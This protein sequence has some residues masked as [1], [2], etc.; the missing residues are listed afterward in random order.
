MFVPPHQLVRLTRK[1][2]IAILTLARPAMHNALVPEL[3][4]DVLG[5]LS[6][7]RADT[8]IAALV[9]A[10]DGP[11]FSIGGD[12]RRFAAEGQAGKAQL[13]AY[14]DRLV[15]LLNET[16]LAMARL[17]QP[18]VAAV[19]GTVTGGSLAFLVAADLVVMGD[20]VVLKA[21]YA[22]AGF[23]PDGGWTARL[24]DLVGPRR[25]AAA[26]LLNRSISAQDALDWGLVHAVAPAAEV[27]ACA[28][29]MAC[30]MA[31]YPV[32]TMRSAKRLVSDLALGEPVGLAARLDAER[33]GFLDLVAGDEAMQ[34]VASF[35]ENFK[36]YPGGD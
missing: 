23:C 15:G 19:H 13:I 1:A 32:G 21:H 5:A 14:A 9:L 36:S 7:V 11:S 31:A 22:S 26:L 28:E 8:S 4:E 33:R 30:R 27:L 17:P 16:A 6:V 25:V 24:A 20:A 10:A 35:L 2:G 3:L 34:G 29:G 18:I 12:M